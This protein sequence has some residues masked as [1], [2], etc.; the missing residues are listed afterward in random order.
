MDIRVKELRRGRQEDGGLITPASL[1]L[2]QRKG[3]TAAMSPLGKHRGEPA[4][5]RPAARGWSARQWLASQA[6]NRQRV[7]WNPGDGSPLSP[8]ANQQ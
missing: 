5:M 7:P 6:R 1:V 8:E 4:H 2:K 3:R